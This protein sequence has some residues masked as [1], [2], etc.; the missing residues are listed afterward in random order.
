MANSDLRLR[1]GKPIVD[2][3]P[4]SLR[5]ALD[6]ITPDRTE[7][8]S[9]IRHLDGARG[10]LSDATERT[11]IPWRYFFDAS[12]EFV[13]GVSEA[14]DE[15][16]AAGPPERLPFRDIVVDRSAIRE[17][18]RSWLIDEV[19][20]RRVAPHEAEALASRLG[21]APLLNK[22]DP[23]CLMQTPRW[24][25]PMARAWLVWRD[26]HIVCEYWPKYVMKSEYWGHSAGPELQDDG[27]PQPIISRIYPVD[28]RFSS[29][30]ADIGFWQSRGKR[31]YRELKTADA[32][33]LKAF[34]SGDLVAEGIDTT[35]RERVR[36]SSPNFHDLRVGVV[37]GQGE[38]VLINTFGKTFY[39][40][41]VYREQLFL[42]EAPSVGAPKTAAD[43]SSL[44]RMS[45]NDKV[46]L[47]FAE[48]KARECF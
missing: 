26:E 15:L 1:P 23:A 43:H 46:A 45:Q 35:T 10:Y 13:R 12:I 3:P 32:L 22:A 11:E 7:Q 4:V 40:P 28:I 44:L 25:L 14:K 6:W 18:K 42:L 5:Q 29:V 16:R 8:A 9:W 20:R 33:L 17:T 36:I 21:L 34:Q 2:G 24:T 31:L 30:E 39:S 47:A 41:T 37:A 38:E 19:Q 27:T 48:M